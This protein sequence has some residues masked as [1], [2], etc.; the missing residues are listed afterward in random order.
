MARTKTGTTRKARHNKI[1][2]ANKGYRLTKSKLY[3]VAKEAYLHAGQYAFA[4]RKKRR[5]DIRRLWIVRLKAALLGQENPMSY[6]R[7]INLLKVKNIL[8]NR[9]VLSELAI[10]SPKAFSSFF[11]F[12]ASK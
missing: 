1:L 12:T 9:K 2:K 4:G 10:K 5:R 3:K 8:L 11:G 7:F 6:S